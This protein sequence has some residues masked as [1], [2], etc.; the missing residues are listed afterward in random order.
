MSGDRSPGDSERAAGVGPAL[1]QGS[2][3]RHW[4]LRLEPD[5]SG[6]SDAG[7]GLP[8]LVRLLLA[9][10]GVTTTA[11]ARSHLGTPR[12]LTPADR[13][14]GLPEAVDRLESA[15]RM[16][17]QVAVFGDFDVDGI[18]ATTLL[19]EALADLGA[20][21]VPYIPDRFTEGYGPNRAAVEGLARGG[22]TLL[23]MADC[24]SSAAG[25]VGLANELGM[26]VVVVDHHSLPPALP[27]ALALVNPKLPGSDY[28]SEPAAVGVAYKVTAELYARLGRAYDSSPHLALVALGTV[29]DLVPLRG[30]NRDLVRL[31][32]DALRESRRPGLVAL[33]EVAQLDLSRSDADTLG[34]DFGPRLNAA[35]RL[36]HASLATDLLLTTNPEEARR[37]AGELDR[38]NTDRKAAT[39][40]ALAELSGLL[41]P[42]QLEAP[43]I[44]AES[45]SISSGIVGL[46]A[47]RLVD[48]HRRPAIVVQVGEEEARGSARSVPNLDITGL[49]SRHADLFLRF[50]G[51]N[52]AAGFT[53]ET[54]R[55]SELRERLIADVADRIGPPGVAAPLEIDAELPI[56]SL[57]RR[58]IQWLE[59]LGPYGM[60]N[61]RPIFLARDTEVI[62]SRAVGQDQRHLQLVIGSATDSW[63]A[64]AFGQAGSLV[65]AGERADLVYR[66]KRDDFAGP[67]AWQLEVRDLRPAGG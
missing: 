47:S 16:G 53:V 49:L 29:C 34:W 65:A 51:H 42:E 7:P 44:V 3:G 2:S 11:Q 18:T 21:P 19:T 15:C 31:G 8:A 24:G 45:A 33:A 60:A 25:E 13:M 50:G 59:L 55:L 28:G 32:L 35:G 4:Q 36:Q 62:R 48:R 17:E 66:L 63:R 64:I 27:P 14:P 23:V 26:D 56:D 9:Q 22:A 46:A 52:A 20:R 5:L 38:L 1:G 39:A 54:R 57:D 37:L 61:P 6:M 40:E 12:D 10:R 67:G 30:E 43:L 41:T 58:T